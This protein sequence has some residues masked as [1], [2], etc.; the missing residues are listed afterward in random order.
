MAPTFSSSH[1][2]QYKAAVALNN[3][4]VSLLQRQCYQDALDTFKDAITLIQFSLRTLVGRRAGDGLNLFSVPGVLVDN[5]LQAAWHRYATSAM[6]P[7]LPALAGGAGDFAILTVSSQQDPSGVQGA[8]SEAMS[9]NGKNSVFCCINVDPVDFEECCIE[10]IDL[11]S[12]LILY[13]FGIAHCLLASKLEANTN[14]EGVLVQKLR[15]SG[16][17]LFRLSEAFLKERL[18][19]PPFHFQGGTVLLISA[20]FTR[21]MVELASHL[22]YMEV[23]EYYRVAYVAL[24]V[25][26]DAQQNLLPTNVRQAAAA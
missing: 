25:S 6:R 22:N 7:V 3:M 18:S 14:F 2:E 21:S 15:Q 10:T 26:I 8:I 4:A 12:N 16:F 13:N 20:L 9:R 17:H 23:S 11:D 19:E 5:V 1:D 24:L